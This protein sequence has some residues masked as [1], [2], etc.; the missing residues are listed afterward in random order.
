MAADDL[1][2]ALGEVRGQGRSHLV[3]HQH[4][5]L[6]RKGSGKIHDPERG[7]RNAPRQARQVEI[8]QPQLA[9]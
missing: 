3:E 1:Q 9:A 4:V 6:D 5:G 8:L 7:E 2:D